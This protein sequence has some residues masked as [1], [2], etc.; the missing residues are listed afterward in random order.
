VQAC[1]TLTDKAQELKA[2]DNITLVKAD[3]GNMETMTAAFKDADAV[4]GKRS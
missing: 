3:M 1:G 2:G 4:F